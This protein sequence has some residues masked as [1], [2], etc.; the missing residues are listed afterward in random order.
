MAALQSNAFLPPLI[1]DESAEV[2]PGLESPAS[3]ASRLVQAMRRRPFQLSVSVSETTADA[4]PV[5]SV[6]L[7]WSGRERPGDS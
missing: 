6:A 1:G 5:L 2:E 7:G 4:H 3:R